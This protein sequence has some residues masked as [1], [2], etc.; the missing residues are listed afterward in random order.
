M[1][2]LGFWAPETVPNPFMMMSRV[3][4]SILSKIYSKIDIL[5]IAAWLARKAARSWQEAPIAVA[6][7]T[8]CWEFG[9]YSQLH[10]ERFGVGAR[11]KGGAF[12]RES[13]GID[14][15]EIR[16]TKFYNT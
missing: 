13:K 3:S 9:D 11:Q 7:R 12:C 2:L 1:N 5:P 6:S 8:L 16:A 10:R 15:D 4:A 14:G